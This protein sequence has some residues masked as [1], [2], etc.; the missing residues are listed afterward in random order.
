MSTMVAQYMPASVTAAFDPADVSPS[1]AANRC[2]DQLYSCPEIGGGSASTN[3]CNSTT[4]VYDCVCTMDDVPDC[5]AYMSTLPYYMCIATYEQCVDNNPIDSEAEAACKAKEECGSF[6]PEF[7]AL[8]Q[9]CPRRRWRPTFPQSR[10]R[11]PLFLHHRARLLVS[12]RPQHHRQLYCQVSGQS[13][14]P[15]LSQQSLLP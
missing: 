5:T 1:D 15:R 3:I 13:Q 10:A 7:Q 9:F 12:P 8:V 4:F 2:S 11:P 14:L 6:D